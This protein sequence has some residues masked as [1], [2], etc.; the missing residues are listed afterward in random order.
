M[1]KRKDHLRV[2]TA[3]ASKY[4]L[5]EKLIARVETFT[6]GIEYYKGSGITHPVFT[7]VGIVVLL[8]IHT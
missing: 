2:N 3:T 5:Q 7:V 1:H 8:Y 6:S 4:P